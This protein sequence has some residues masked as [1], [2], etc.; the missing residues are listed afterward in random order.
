VVMREKPVVLVADDEHLN[1]FTLERLLHGEGFEPVLTVNGPECRAAARERRPDIV[2]LDIMMP[3]E[4]GLQ[5]LEKLKAEPETAD[6]PVILLSA[7]S[8]VE[9]KVRGFDLGA[10][11]YVTKP[12]QMREVMARIR[13]QLKL[14]AAYETVIRTQAERLRQVRDAQ[15]A[16]L[17]SPAD[18]PEAGFAVAY[19]P[20]LEAGGDFY[21]VF[22]LGGGFGYFVADISGHDLKASF[23]TAGLKAVLR[24]NAGPLYT[25]AE[26]LKNVNGVLRHVLAPG[27]FLTACYALLNPRRTTLTLL[28][29]GHPAPVLVP[30]GDG[31]ARLLE[32]Q[33][34]ILGA[35]ESISL[36]P[37]CL[38]LHPGD[39][40]YLYTDGL[41]ESAEWDLAA[42]TARL[43][44]ACA[45]CRGQSLAESVQTV[46]EAM[47]DGRV[48]SDDAVLLGLEA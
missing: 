28:S 39:R 18:L 38:N 29:C 13:G 12:F 25:P 36:A 9:T 37:L 16:I 17:P 44:A 1:R 33:G 5:T 2:L 24:Q 10:V 31:P 27:Q 41:V 4:S 26:T 30:A 21:D 19:Q 34:D 46:R 20:V 7:L 22:G 45:S 48:M 23:V 35:F 15:K 11:D 40:I 42:G 47:C 8:D 6:I 14:A 3:G 43:L 32:A